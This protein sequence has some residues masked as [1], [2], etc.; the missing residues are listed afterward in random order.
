MKLPTLSVIVPNYNHAQ[1]LPTCLEALLS[2]SVPPTEIIVIDD[3]ST[4]NS[5]EVIK[6]LAARHPT[7]KLYQNDKNRGVSYTLNRGIDLATS[8][9]SYFPGADD[10]ILPGFLEKSL[11]LLAEHPQAGI[12]CTV[13]DWREVA[14]G[15]HWCMGAG[16]TDKP[17]Y[18]SP[19][20]LVELEKQGRLFIPNHTAIMKTTALVEAGKF[21]LE[22]KSSSDWFAN[23]AI[24]LRYG[25]CVV[26]EP[27][28]VFN[29]YPNSYF[30]RNRK[31]KQNYRAMLETILDLLSRPEYRDVAEMMRR[32]GTLFIFGMPMVKLL[33][34]RREFR[35]FLTP[36]LLRKGIWHSAKVTLKPYIPT[37]LGNW[38]LQVAGYRA[39]KPAGAGSLS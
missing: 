1:L 27:L 9:Y 28:A 4:D 10:E 3:G 26:P 32:G 16:M 30:H 22:L 36:L 12:S 39:K 13:G 14:T 8:E 18:F 25:L 24:A 20:Q 6:A 7:I 35:G 38:Y 23:N 17:V 21:I 11:R 2:Q 5:V 33:M 34:R 31:D 19:D 29:I 37:F 15:L